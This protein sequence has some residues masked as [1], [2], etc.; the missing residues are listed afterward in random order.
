MFMVIDISKQ[1]TQ[2]KS[3]MCCHLK[4]YVRNGAKQNT[5]E[6]ISSLSCSILKRNLDLGRNVATNEFP[7][8]KL[9][10]MYIY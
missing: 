6:V 10:P 2:Q 9:G 1:L 4:A 3:S 8:G 7:Q 5:S